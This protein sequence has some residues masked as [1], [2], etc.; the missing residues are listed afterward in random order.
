MKRYHALLIAGLLSLSALHVIAEEAAKPQDTSTKAA[1]EKQKKAEKKPT[2]KE[3]ADCQVVTGSRIHVSKPKK[4]ADGK[5]E[6]KSSS[7]M[8]SY[9]REEIERTGEMNLDNALRNLDPSIR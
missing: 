4:D 9:S 5:C 7:A 8:R 3:T 2:K 6:S 1:E